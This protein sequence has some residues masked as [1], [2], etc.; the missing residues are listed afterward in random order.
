[1][2]EKMEINGRTIIIRCP[3]PEAKDELRQAIR[4]VCAFTSQNTY[5]L[6]EHLVSE[7]FKNLLKES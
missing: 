6:L 3:S 5:T 4:I 7:R 2:N 1:M